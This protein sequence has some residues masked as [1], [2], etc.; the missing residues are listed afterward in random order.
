MS[1]DQSPNAHVD[2]PRGGVGVDVEASGSDDPFDLKEPTTWES[3]ADRV[4]FW[5][6]YPTLALSAVL[7]LAGERNPSDRN[8]TIALTVAAALWT[9]VTFSRFGIPSRQ[10]QATLYIYFAGFVV[11]AGLMMFH[12]P[13]FVL[14]CITGFLHAAL[15][16]PWV[17]AFAALGATSMIV[18]SQIVYPGGGAIE[19]AIY[20]SIVVLQTAAVG[21]GVYGGERM[22]DV[23]DQRRTALEEL[24]AARIENEWLHDQLVA[25]AREA[26]IHDERE[27]L[28]GEIHDTI[29]QG[30]TGVITQI[31][32]VHQNWDDEAAARA[33]LE[34][35]S[36]LARDSLEDARRS[37]HALR[38]APL[39]DQRL[40]EAIAG[41][42][43]KWSELTHIP[44][45][46]H[47]AGQ[48]M[49]VPTEVEVTMLRA[50]QEGLANVAKHADASRVDLTLSFMEDALALDL[51]DDGVGF[52]TDAPLHEESFGLSAM[53]QRVDAL[54]GVVAIESRPSEGCVL[55]VHIPVEPEESDA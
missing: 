41:A 50:A 49:Q 43:A 46:V 13:V 54:D 2:P 32:A 26:G 5:L 14:Y 1:K 17:V 51:R 44:V 45:E 15:L 23:A 10:R 8:W 34:N 31:E 36:G 30:L 53:K 24:H 48:P 37:V 4:F 6:P 33:H 52:D 21:F 7:A 35:A 55:H 12:A 29:A 27:R 16:R 22:L 28:A 18:F 47:T 39:E 25:Q 38:P 3:G 11:I 42:A 40:P 20:L 19:W 9:L